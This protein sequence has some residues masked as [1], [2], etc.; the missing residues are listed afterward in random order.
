VSRSL[1]RWD[2]TRPAYKRYMSLVRQAWALVR[3]PPRV[4]AFYLRGVRTARRI[5]DQW[6]LDVAA[7]PRELAALLR[8]ARGQTRVA[9][10]GTGTAWTAISLALSDPGRLV[11]SYDIQAR[12]E[13]ER[14]L[15]L[16]PRQARDRIRLLDRPGGTGPDPA[17][18][19]DLVFI[20]SSHEK[21]ET[22]ATFET[23]NRSLAS[24]GIVCLHDYQDPA[25][26]G[27]TEAVE[28]LGLEGQ[29][30]GKLFVCRKAG[31]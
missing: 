2:D 21:A 16:I 25:Y 19:V 27:V 18:E 17:P 1:F 29:K 3:L 5:G 7:R 4:S 14:Y 15:S 24:D 23:W 26:P 28:A 11:L 30:E 8:I 31:A 13:R 12:P 9:E 10:I 6:T 22:M 20:D